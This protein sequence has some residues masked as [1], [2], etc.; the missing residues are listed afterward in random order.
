MDWTPLVNDGPTLIQHAFE[1]IEQQLLTPR[2]GFRGSVP[3]ILIVVAGETL[4]QPSGGIANALEALEAVADAADSAMVRY[5]VDI[6]SAFELP[7]IDGL[8]A[9]VG[10]LLLED[11]TAK[12]TTAGERL[13]GMS[14]DVRT[15]NARCSNG[16][17]S[18]TS[19][20]LATL[21]PAIREVVEGPCVEHTPAPST[22]APTTLPTT[23]TMT[24]FTATLTT[25]TRTTTSATPL[26]LLCNGVPDQAV[27]NS[28][29][30]DNC[31][32]E[33]IGKDVRAGCPVLCDT[34]TTSTVVI[35]TTTITTRTCNGQVDGDGCSDV[36]A[37]DCTDET[38]GKDVR[39][40]CPVLCD[41]CTTTT[42]QTTSTTTP[43][44]CETEIDLIFLIDQSGSTCGDDQMPNEHF[45]AEYGKKVEEKN[46][47]EATACSDILQ[48]FGH[49][50]EPDG[51]VPYLGDR[52]YK[53]EAQRM[54]VRSIIDQLKL[55]SSR[56]TRVG[57]VGFAEPEAYS[58]TNE[59]K[60]A[61]NGY[62]K[63]LD[64]SSDR[65]EIETVLSDTTSAGSTF[66]HGALEVAKQMFDTAARPTAR[67]VVVVLLDGIPAEF[68]KNSP[69]AATALDKTV[70]ALQ[71]QSTVM[72]VGYGDGN[73]A[74]TVNRLASDQA[75]SGNKWGFHAEHLE[76]VADVLMEDPHRICTEVSK[77]TARRADVVF[78][79]ERAGAV[80]GCGADWITDQLIEIANHLKADLSADGVRVAAVVYGGGAPDDVVPFA[81]L[82]TDPDPFDL[83]AALAVNAHSNAQGGSIDRAVATARTELLQD[84]STN[85]REHQVPITFVILNAGSLNARFESN[86]G[87]LAAELALIASKEP[88]GN[89]PRVIEYFGL[90]L[91]DDDADEGYGADG[92]DAPA[93]PGIESSFLADLDVA[94]EG[95]CPAVAPVCEDDA[96]CQSLEDVLLSNPVLAQNLCSDQHVLA[97]CP[98][99]CGACTT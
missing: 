68:D 13:L 73:N 85:F 91:N 19:A 10:N 76:T 79:V 36:T 62:R 40:G 65:V 24:S 58:S 95:P 92:G 5:V 98:A 11:S 74:D 21:A 47:D 46:F 8:S 87:A 37:A 51:K 53:H 86:A 71:N 96:S 48:E 75:A 70:A 33:I 4:E 2:A 72:V 32:D 22:D 69:S 57:M 83:L 45:D 18:S 55:G 42:T 93:C 3:L 1:T 81:D 97:T 28:V 29:T 30:A 20:G 34:C 50:A 26:V 6:R 54:F 43:F 59:P 90:K 15:I 17:S 63:L 88:D 82:T 38:F 35:T 56:S 9:E 94:V 41:T 78:V 44:L 39:A 52:V 99:M 89:A 49:F 25:T 23:V 7:L 60:G 27:C 12:E 77:C 84:N 61:I 80:G 67:Q 14:T 64:F 66:V 31:T 16:G